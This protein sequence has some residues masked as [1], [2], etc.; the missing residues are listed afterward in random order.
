[1]PYG[2][3][4]VLIAQH[5][6]NFPRALRRVDYAHVARRHTPFGALRYHEV[7]I[8]MGGDLRQ[9]GNDEHLTT[10]LPTTVRDR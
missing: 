9:V 10:G 5:T 1:V 4:R 2:G 8:G 6:G 3:R 7:A